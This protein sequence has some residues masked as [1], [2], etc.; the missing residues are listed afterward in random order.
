M[1]NAQTQT[2]KSYY[3]LQILKAPSAK[4]LAIIIFA[5]DNTEDF[6]IIC[7]AKSACVPLFRLLII[8]I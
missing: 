6:I 7:F 1:R 5:L 3:I 8:F 2:I 4:S